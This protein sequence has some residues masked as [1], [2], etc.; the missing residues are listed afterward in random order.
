MTPEEA[1]ERLLTAARFGHL[2]EAQQAI[3]SGASINLNGN[4]TTPLHRASE[5]GHTEIA[6]LLINKGADIEARDAG[7]MRPLHLAAIYRHAEVARLLIQHGA[8]VNAY[9]GYRKTPED[10]ITQD[11]TG[12]GL[13]YQGDIDLLQIL[14]DAA[15]NPGQGHAG[16]VAKRRGSS[17]PQV[18]D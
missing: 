7:Y 8:D 2:D 4:V 16:R 15:Q 10:R 13:I 17:E 1:T 5:A 11:L 14:R 12:P 3:H 6:R 18:G 9:D